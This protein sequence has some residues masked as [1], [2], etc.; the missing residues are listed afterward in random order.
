M[1]N[2][3]ELWSRIGSVNKN[4]VIV[5]VLKDE[6]SLYESRIEPSGTGYLYDSIS[7]L[8]RRLEELK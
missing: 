8:K 5:A 3:E 4:D 7:Q 1:E 6:I 2:L